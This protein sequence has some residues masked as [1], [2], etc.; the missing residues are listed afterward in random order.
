[1]HILIGVIWVNVP[2]KC[3]Y[4][5]FTLKIIKKMFFW[6]NLIY[7]ITRRIWT[8]SEIDFSPEFEIFCSAAVAVL[9][10]FIF[11][12]WMFLCVFDHTTISFAPSYSSSYMFNNV[13]PNMF[14]YWPVSRLCSWSIW[15]LWFVVWLGKC[16]VL[17]RFYLHNRFPCVS[18]G[19]DR[20]ICIFSLFYGY[21]FILYDR[22][23]HW[24]S[25]RFSVFPMQHRCR[26]WCCRC[27]CYCHWYLVPFVTTTNTL[28]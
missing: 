21:L 13:Y 19:F 12:A 22:V 1:M 6:F 8:K 20:I 27:R 2:K 14:L 25:L 24:T 23:V 26:R 9:F 11:I 10:L 18:G 16:F 17:F 28:I 4:L 3:L 5:G 7:F 15:F